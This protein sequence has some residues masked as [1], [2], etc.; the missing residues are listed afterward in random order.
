MEFFGDGVANL[1]VDERIGVDV[2][3]TETTCLSS[4][5]VTDD[6]VKEFYEIHNRKEDFAELTLPEVV[7]YDGLVEVDLSAESKT[8]VGIA[9][10]R[11]DMFFTVGTEIK[12]YSFETGCLN[13]DLNKGITIGTALSSSTTVKNLKI[14]EIADSNLPTLSFNI[15][16]G[17]QSREEII[18]AAFFILSCYCLIYRAAEIEYNESALERCEMTRK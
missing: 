14:T 16:K 5:W 1:T 18:S 10:A 15:S 2:M 6:K 13:A 4:I 11:A 7:Y 3:T 12:T 8:V 17:L 9:A